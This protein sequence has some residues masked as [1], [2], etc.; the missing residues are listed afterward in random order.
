MKRIAYL[1]VALAVVSSLAGCL[2]DGQELGQ[3][4]DQELDD[5]QL[6]TIESNITILPVAGAWTYGPLIPLSN[7]CGISGLRGE[8]GPFRLDSVTTS[9]FRVTPNDGTA[10][11]ACSYS[12]A[13]FS[14]PNRALLVHDLR[15]SYDAKFTVKVSAIGVMSDSRHAK[16]KQDALVTCVGTQCNLF[17][18]TPC[19]FVDTFEVHTL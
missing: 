7:N 1:S 12:N 17:G 8:V 5:S 15:P 9:A 6:G 4:E 3:D 13:Q 18:S 2:D 16:G 10:A 19:G 11:F 14:C